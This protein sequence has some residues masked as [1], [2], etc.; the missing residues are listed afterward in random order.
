MS[1]SIKYEL[2]EPILEC[3]GLSVARGG[4]PIL[5]NLDLE[6]RDLY[7]P[8]STMGQ[9]VGLLGPSGVGKTTLF[10][11]LAG[12]DLPDTGTIHVMKKPLRRGDVGVVAQHYPLFQHRTVMGNLM[13]VGGK[14]PAQLE[15]EAKQ[16]L[17]RFGV[18]EHANK[19]PSQL[20][21][22]Q[23]QRVAIAQQFL[24]SDSLLLMDEPFSGL[25]PL[26]ID[27]VVNFIS[28]I[29][30]HDEMKTFILVTH[31]IASALRICDTVWLLGRDRDAK[32]NPIPGARIMSNINLIDRGIAWRE[33]MVNSPEFF[34]VVEEIRELFPN[35]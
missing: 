20:S 17:E 23:R 19:Y 5:K 2:R 24:C 13:V 29:I 28:E 32:G 35:L 22:G 18:A 10:R 30:H 3:R 11:T 34:K 15:K 8:G 1:S 33:D 31:D 27:R 26:A 4:V 9:V 12:L 7:L 25:D 16:I 6:I 21:G 14:P